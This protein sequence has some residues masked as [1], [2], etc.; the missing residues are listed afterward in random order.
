M[1]GKNNLK[2]KEELDMQKQNF[3]IDTTNPQ[4]VYFLSNSDDPSNIISSVIL[5]GKNYANWSCL[6]VNALKSNNKLGFA[7]GSITKPLMTSP[8]ILTWERCNSMVIEW[9]YNVI[10]K[11]LHGL[12]AYVETARQIWVDLKESYC[13]GHAIWIHQIKRELSL[14]TQGKQSIAE[15]FTNLKT[16]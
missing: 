9:L 10:N 3:S 2:H 6:T 4:S 13:Q 12:V 7:Y 14:I 16:L 1:E 11:N 15:Y 8:K 5:N